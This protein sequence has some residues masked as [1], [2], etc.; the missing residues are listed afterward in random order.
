[1]S[2]LAELEN[3]ALSPVDSRIEDFLSLPVTEA[4]FKPFSW[5]KSGR[6]YRALGVEAFR[7]ILRRT[8]EGSL[9]E[10]TVV[11][12]VRH[13]SSETLP[14]LKKLEHWT[15]GREISH[16]IVLPVFIGSTALFVAENRPVEALINCALNIGINVYPIMLQRYNRL[17]IQRLINYIEKRDARATSSQ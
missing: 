7:H 11:K 1:M 17:R 4:Y 13:L 2:Y 6:V 12:N 8:K 10:E 9:P 3:R 16:L 15:R 14:N 5:E